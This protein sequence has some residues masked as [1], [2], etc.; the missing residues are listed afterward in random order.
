MVIII[1]HRFRRQIFIQRS[2]R[3]H[4]NVTCMVINLYISL[5]SKFKIILY[6]LVS[7]FSCSVSLNKIKF[8]FNSLVYKKFEFWINHNDIINLL[9]SEIIMNLIG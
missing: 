8:Q 4:C 5:L 3:S 7:Y 1:L 9:C 2:L 6:I